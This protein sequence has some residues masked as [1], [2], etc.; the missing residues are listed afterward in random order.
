LVS[1]ARDWRAG[2]R[3]LILARI[4]SRVSQE[5]FDSGDELT[6]P[7]IAQRRRFHL[8]IAEKSHDFGRVGQRH[9]R[10]PLEGGED[11]EMEPH[12]HSELE[13][14]QQVWGLL[15]RVF[16]S[17]NLRTLRIV[18]VRH[19]PMAVLDVGSFHR[20]EHDVGVEPIHHEIR[21]IGEQRMIMLR[22]EI[23][24]GGAGFSDR[25]SHQMPFELDPLRFEDFERKLIRMYEQSGIRG[26]MN[27]AVDSNV[28]E[29]PIALPIPHRDDGRP[30]QSLAHDATRPRIR[31]RTRTH[32]VHDHG[33]PEFMREKHF[34]QIGLGIPV[35]KN[36][37]PAQD[38]QVKPLDFPADFFSGQ[39]SDRNGTLDLVPTQRILRVP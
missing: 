28:L 39:V 24:R 7:D 3:C 23:G 30:V 18:H 16:P 33:N 36:A 10:C 12:A 29:Q 15:S 35:I 34:P 32:R 9:E 27:L 38:E 5:R 4:S 11:Q 25:K 8:Q 26:Q 6:D 17:Q 37:A 31:E 2:R 21:R 13:T 19:D 1:R 22:I 14:S 20:N